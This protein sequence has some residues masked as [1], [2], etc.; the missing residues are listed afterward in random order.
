MFA[1]YFRRP[2]ETSAALDDAGWLHTGDIIR[3]DEDGSLFFVGRSKDMIKTG[4]E[5][6]YPAEVES[7]LLAA[8]PELAEVVVVGIPSGRWGEEVV[9]MA[10]R[11]EGQRIEE[12]KLR[13]RG[14]SLLAG[15]KVPKQVFFVDSLPRN[16][17]GKVLRRELRDRLAGGG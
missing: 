15:F 8:N 16:A 14:R 11:K 7:R 1:G 6:V 5:N 3:A 2:E 17:M 9:A 4:G 13:E 10:V 12:D